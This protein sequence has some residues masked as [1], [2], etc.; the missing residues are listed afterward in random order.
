MKKFLS[1]ALTL[2]MV[3]AFV[4]GGIVQPPQAAAADFTANLVPGVLPAATGPGQFGVL[5]GSSG[6]INVVADAGGNYVQYTNNG[7]SRDY[8]FGYVLPSPVTAGIITF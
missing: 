5:H 1:W 7:S 4:P 6:T 3:L 8:V 2:A